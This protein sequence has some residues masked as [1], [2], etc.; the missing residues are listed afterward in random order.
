MEN[1]TKFFSF[2]IIGL[3]ASNL[4]L[5]GFLVLKPKQHPPKPE[6]PKNIIIEKLKFD[7]SQIESY[8]NLI[9]N[10]IQEVKAAERKLNDAKTLYYQ[11]LKSG[12]KEVALEVLLAAQ[13]EIEQIHFN[14]FEDIKNLCKPEQLEKFNELV[15]ELGRLFSS[16]KPPKRP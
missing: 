2:L 8:Q 12:N 1:K 16:Q 9:D 15:D 10:H 4:L 13:K 3:L 6:R 14:H 11:T 7:K 5:I